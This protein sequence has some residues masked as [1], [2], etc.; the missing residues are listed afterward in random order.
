MGPSQRLTTTEVYGSP[1]AQLGTEAELAPLKDNISQ[2][3]SPSS[4]SY[5]LSTSSSTAFPAPG[6]V[7]GRVG[8][9]VPFRAQPSV[10]FSPH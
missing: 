5:N 10:F 3:S 4:N 6:R 1:W 2:P 9:D 7:R 8:N